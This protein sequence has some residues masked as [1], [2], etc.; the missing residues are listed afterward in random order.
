MV[1]NIKFEDACNNAENTSKENLIILNEIKK[2]L[3]LFLGDN[4]LKYEDKIN[5]ITDL[6]IRLEEAEYIHTKSAWRTKILKKQLN[7]DNEWINS[8]NKRVSEYAH[9]DNEISLISRNK[10][11]VSIKLAKIINHDNYVAL[12]KISSEIFSILKDKTLDFEYKKRKIIE[13]EDRKHKANII[14]TDSSI[15]VNILRGQLNEDKRE[16][17]INEMIFADWEKHEYNT[18]MRIINMSYDEREEILNTMN[19]ERRN[20]I[21]ILI[22]SISHDGFV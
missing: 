15:E 18:A 14:L 5:G 4:T 21:N 2:E 10:I 7:I 16:T 6:N 9:I 22:E 13:L 3:V 19:T 1:R 8:S 12:T 17:A 20:S 11:I